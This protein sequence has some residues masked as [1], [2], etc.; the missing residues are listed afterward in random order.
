VGVGVLVEMILLPL[1][2]V[3]VLGTG[4]GSSGE[5]IV[6]CGTEADAMPDGVIESTGDV[7]VVVNKEV[8]VWIVNPPSVDVAAAEEGDAIGPPGSLAV[9]DRGRGGL[10][11][12]TSPV[13]VGT[14]AILVEV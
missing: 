8:C 14:A 6:L 11:E 13:E 10:S 12:T 5:L 7:L 4:I 2:V 9:D 1:P 3:V